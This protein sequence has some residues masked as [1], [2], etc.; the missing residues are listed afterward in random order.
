MDGLIKTG[1]RFRLERGCLWIVALVS[2]WLAGFNSTLDQHRF[3]IYWMLIADN[4]LKLAAGLEPSKR[5]VY[6]YHQQAL[7]V[8]SVLVGL[9]ASTCWQ[10]ILQSLSSINYR[11]HSKLLARSRCTSIEVSQS[12]VVLDLPWLAS[13]IRTEKWDLDRWGFTDRFERTKVRGSWSKASVSPEKHAM[14]TWTILVRLWAFIIGSAKLWPRS[15][16]RA[17]R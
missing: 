1:S 11:N 15:V 16:N 6:L 13:C 2:W 3:Q 14:P 7:E 12:T 4:K 8:K 10:N 17:G 9:A 5:R